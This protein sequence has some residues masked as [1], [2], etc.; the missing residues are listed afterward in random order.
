MRTTMANL[1]KILNSLFDFSGKTVIELGVGTGRLTKTYID[2]AAR[3][4]LF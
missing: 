4:F 2:K 1:P 3:A